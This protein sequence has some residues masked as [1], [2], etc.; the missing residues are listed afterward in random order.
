VKM[1]EMTNGEIVDLHE[2]Q[3]CYRYVGWFLIQNKAPFNVLSAFHT[4]CAIPFMHEK[5]KSKPIKKGNQ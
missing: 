3:G 1:V 5:Y 2:K 4:A